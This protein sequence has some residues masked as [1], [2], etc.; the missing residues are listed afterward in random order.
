MFW[1]VKMY[2][3]EMRGEMIIKAQVKAA[4]ETGT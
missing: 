4:P 2:K 3:S 1:L